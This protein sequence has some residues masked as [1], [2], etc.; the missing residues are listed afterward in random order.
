MISPKLRLVFGS[1]HRYTNAQ[2]QHDSFSSTWRR[3]LETIVVSLRHPPMFE[4]T[5]KYQDVCNCH[6]VKYSFWVEYNCRDLGN[7]YLPHW[8]HMRTC[9]HVALAGNATQQIARE[10]DARMQEFAFNKRQT[11]WN[12]CIK[13]LFN[14]TIEVLYDTRIPPPPL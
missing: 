2:R 14:E 9:S 13:Q 7:W 3:V 6:Q 5:F 4:I 8:C 12:R 10:C 11:K 1:H